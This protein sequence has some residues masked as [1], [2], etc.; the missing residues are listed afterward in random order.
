MVKN[1]IYLKIAAEHPRSHVV[2]YE[3]LCGDPVGVSKR[4]FQFLGWELG[5]QTLGFLD[6]STHEKSSV[7]TLMRGNQPYFGIYRETAEAADKWKTALPPA[8]RDRVL[9]MVRPFFPTYG[10]R[11][12]V[13]NAA[14]E[15]K[16]LI[17]QMREQVQNIE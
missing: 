10:D 7:G 8:Q 5:T 1:R 16:I 15:M 9:D 17:E 3:A 11:G 14:M 4:L 13:S 6:Q 12:E 2:V